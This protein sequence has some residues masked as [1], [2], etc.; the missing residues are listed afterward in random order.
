ML[1]N[2]KTPLPLLLLFVALPAAAQMRDLETDPGVG[3]TFV[4]TFPIPAE[5]GTL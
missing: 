3:T 5:V 4:I 1:F 2:A